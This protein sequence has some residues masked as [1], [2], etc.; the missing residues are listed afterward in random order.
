[1]SRLAITITSADGQLK[2]LASDEPHATDIP[3]GLSL[4]T[5]IPGGFDTC[6]FNLARR[7]DHPRDIEL[8][9]H[10]RVYGPGNTTVWEG[11]VVQLPRRATDT[12]EQGV[13]CVGWSSHLRD[14]PSFCEVYVDRDLSAWGQTSRV[15]QLGLINANYSAHQP[16]PTMRDSSSAQPALGLVFPGRWES[17]AKP[18]CEALYDAGPGLEIG[19]IYFD[20]AAAASV[21]FGSGHTWNVQVLVHPTDN[22]TGTGTGNIASGASAPNFVAQYFEPTTPGRYATMLFRND[23]TP[24]GVFGRE[25][26]VTMRDVTVYGTHGLTRRG[27]DPGGFYLSDIVADIVGRTAPLLRF[28]TGEGGSIETNQFIVTH[29]VYRDPV[30][31]EEALQ[32]ANVFALWEWGVYDNRE[33]FWRP[34]DPNR[35]CWELRLSDGVHLSNE[36]EDADGHYN[37]VVVHYQDPAGVRRVAGPPG[38]GFD[39][40]HADLQDT[41]ETNPVNRHGIQRRWGRLDISFPCDD[42]SAV[43]LGRVWLAEH[44]IAQHRGQAE[45][46]GPVAHHPTKGPRPAYEIRAGDFVRFTDDHGNTSIPR[47][48]IKTHYTH[49]DDRMVLDLSNTVFKL[50]AILERMGVAQVG[51][52]A[53]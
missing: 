16:R 39:V 42:D 26:S 22:P 29:L 6:E 37:G 33:F 31:G 27:P 5:T 20:P 12:F 18:N 23:A 24:G 44:S 40:E 9:D 46:T 25:Y 52:L 47:R 10:V 51:V 35:L 38:S 30:T 32:R 15:R 50:E 3:Q 4:S 2:R 36:G 19:A 7:L 48:V 43:Q 49:D 41:S 45:I 11:R 1:M 8:F 14:D 21:S 17:P 34:P 13:G 28:T 53:S